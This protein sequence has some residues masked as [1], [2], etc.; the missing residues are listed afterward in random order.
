MTE[1]LA[2]SFLHRLF[3]AGLLTP[4]G[5]D[6]LYGRSGV[7]D[8][9]IERLKALLRDATKDEPKDVF[10][11]PPGMAEGQFK[12]S[13]YYANFP[14]LAGVVHSF[15]GDERAHRRVLQCMAVG[16]GWM[17]GQAPNEIILTPAACYPVYPILARRG[18]VPA[19][20]YL[21]DLC[22]YCFRHEPSLEPTRM[23]MFQMQEFVRVGSKDQVLAF[24]AEWLER[25]PKIIDTLGLPHEIDVA[26]DPFFGRAGALL[27][28]SQRMQELKFELLVPV[29]DGRPPTACVSFN[30]HMDHFGE[31]WEMHGEDGSVTQTACIG[32][33]L[34]RLTLALLKHHGLDPAQWPAAVRAVMW[35]D[36]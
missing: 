14:Q 29:N 11:F 8:D 3:D 23:Q 12:R 31:A 28:N 35:G 27:A 36:G 19:K 10:R 18:A 5:V 16:E 9:I 32:F 26:N 25:A 20:G 4:T 1:D 13:G 2:P 6:G 15:M 7:F 33:G 30:Y 22:S 21:V 24:R 34:D 17:E